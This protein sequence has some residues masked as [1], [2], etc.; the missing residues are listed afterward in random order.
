MLTNLWTILIPN[1][2]PDPLPNAAA[3]AASELRIFVV[4][5]R[6]ALHF[7]SFLSSSHPTEQGYSEWLVV[8]AHISSS[9][10]LF[11]LDAGHLYN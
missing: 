9:S 10:T 3:A 1:I 2:S 5:K 11:F 4:I 7:N 6:L 8:P